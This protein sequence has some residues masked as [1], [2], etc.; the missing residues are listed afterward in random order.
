MFIDK[1]KIFVAAGRG[2]AGCVSFRREKYVPFGGPDGGNGGKGGDVYL[3]AHGQVKTLMDLAFRPHYEALSGMPGRSS[4][5]YGRGAEDLI[6][7]VPV[8]TIVRKDGVLVADMIKDG[9][10]LLVAKGGRGGR[11]NASFKTGR[12]TAPRIA[13]KGE[14]GEKVSLSME[15]RLI[16]D[17]GL[18]GFPN[19]GKS[20]FLS[21][22][23]AARPKIA[24]YPFTTLY[25]NL[26]VAN[27]GGKHFVIADIPGLIEGAH[28]GK[29]LGYEFLR[30]IT[31]T[32]VLVFV[33]DLF[34]FDG[35]SAY[36]NYL[37]LNKELSKYS[38]S[39]PK[40]LSLIVANKTDLTDSDEKLTELRRR[41][42]GK[43]I[44]PVSAATTAGIDKVLLA[45]S[46]MLDKTVKEYQEF[47][48]SPG[49]KKYVYQ[50]EFAVSKNGDTFVI[51]GAKVEK[52]AAMT[53]FKEDESQLRFWNILKKIGVVKVLEKMGIIDGDTVAIGKEEFTYKE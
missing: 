17:V 10:K 4:D 24:D 3:L 46:K 44:F 53:D 16:A 25:P 48:E 8:G 38:K 19:A 20:T 12:H 37:S 40:K 49:V 23:S 2:G 30:H 22:A 28:E 7:K 1:A 15:L 50:P 27:V 52:L 14:P 29:G 6:I 35:K 42:K 43:K 33:I 32:K 13:E 36:Q 26:G 51:T 34:G 47:D 11:G 9:E 18:V 21:V 39:T 45:V 31:R 41:L 5:K